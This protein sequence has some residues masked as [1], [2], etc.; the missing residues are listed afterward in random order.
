MTCM[1]M[2]GEFHKLNG[3]AIA[4]PGAYGLAVVRTRLILEEF[5]ETYIALHEN[6]VVE[7]AD[8]LADLLY[9]IVGTGV[10]YGVSVRDVFSAPCKPVTTEFTRHSIEQFGAHFMPRMTGMT[11]A[12]ASGAAGLSI[13][14]QFMANVVCRAGAD[15]GFPMAELFG[16]VH[17]SN[18]TKTFAPNTPGGKYGAVNPKGPG[19]S[20]PDIEGVL[21]ITQPI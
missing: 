19:Y 3:N 15:W 10:A 9:V 13:P 14:L 11:A 17:R 8:G 2:V 21:A 1:E 4:E 18:M 7:A 6:N 5:A 20:P 12:L 16:E